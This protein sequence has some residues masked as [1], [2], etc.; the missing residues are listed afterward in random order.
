MKTFLEQSFDDQR[1]S[2]NEASVF[3]QMLE[4][5]KADADDLHWIRREV[6]AVAS[7]T[8]RHP[9]DREALA[10]VD[11]L[12]KVI[13]SQFAAKAPLEEVLFF[14]SDKSLQR[15][16][17]YL[18][19][20][21]KTLDICVF[22]ITNNEI[23]SAI[24]DAHERGVTVRIISDDEKAYDRGSDTIRLN[25]AGI[26]VRFDDGPSH[27]HH[28][29]AVIDGRLLLNGSF[30]WT[31][32][33]SIENY[34]NVQITDLPKIVQKFSDEFASLWTRFDPQARHR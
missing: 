27:M 6:F 24:L 17:S 20:A 28:K 30:N 1:L 15:V 32:S 19:Q 25:Q 5:A 33:A 8:I 12:V 7:Q 14:P 34:E 11:E 26:P 4:E 3:K 10:W 18:K 21:Q 23:A 16:L 31:R 2:R 13:I 9:N 22:T 29:F